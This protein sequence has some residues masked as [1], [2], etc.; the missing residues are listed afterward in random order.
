[1]DKILH[2]PPCD[3]EVISVERILGREVVWVHIRIRPGYRVEDARADVKGM[4]ANDTKFLASGLVGHTDLYHIG[5]RIE[6]TPPKKSIRAELA[7]LPNGK[8]KRVIEDLQDA[9]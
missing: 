4:H 5:L 8:M 7:G 2:T 9:Q 6:E 1:M 3:V